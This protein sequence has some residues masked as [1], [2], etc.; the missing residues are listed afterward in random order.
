MEKWRRVVWAESVGEESKNAAARV[1]GQGV[2]HDRTMLCRMSMKRNWPT[3]GQDC[4]G[5][6]TKP[7]SAVVA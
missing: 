5:G 2:E 4:D 1:Q 7:A 3:D 6:E